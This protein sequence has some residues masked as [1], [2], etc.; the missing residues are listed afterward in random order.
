MAEATITNVF[1]NEVDS[2]ASEV[3]T[4]FSDLTTFLNNSVIQLDGSINPTANLSLAGNR[5]VDLAAA[6]ASTDAAQKAYIDSFKAVSAFGKSG[7]ATSSSTNLVTGFD[8][9]INDPNS[10][11][12]FGADDGLFTIPSDG[13]YIVMPCWYQINSSNQALFQP[14]I[15]DHRIAADGS[16]EP[17]PGSVRTL[18]LVRT[19]T[20][21]KFRMVCI[22]ILVTSS[23]CGRTVRQPI[24]I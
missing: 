18:V 19:I 6:S 12:S 16:S 20:I 13:F 22:C 21:F 4:N 14:T 23:V 11:V 8:T 9:V 24:M 17:R 7:S 5:V 2:L 1:S 10:M 3:N 15:N